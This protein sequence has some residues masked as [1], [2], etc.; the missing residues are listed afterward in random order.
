M[1]C[2]EAELGRET[3]RGMMHANSQ[4]KD[5]AT[6]RRSLSHVHR[7]TQIDQIRGRAYLHADLMIN[8]H[9]YCC[10]SKILYSLPCSCL[11]LLVG[12]FFVCIL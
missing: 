9:Y 8:N 2:H 6:C 3:S 4:K 7:H 11:Q 10:N 5:A 1:C 12:F